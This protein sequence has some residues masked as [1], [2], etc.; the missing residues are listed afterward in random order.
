MPG[1]RRRRWWG[2]PTSLIQPDAGDL[3]CYEGPR[4]SWF[5]VVRWATQVRGGGPHD[6]WLVVERM[7]PDYENGVIPQLIVDMLL[8][9]EVTKFT[10]QVGKRAP[11]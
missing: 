11:R 5:H 6:L 4:G 3:L 10:A 9:P 8:D 2:D 7:E 1:E